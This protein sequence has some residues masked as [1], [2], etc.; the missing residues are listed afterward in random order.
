MLIVEPWL[1]WGGFTGAKGVLGA[2]VEELDHV[3]IQQW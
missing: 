3:L 1:G 2:S